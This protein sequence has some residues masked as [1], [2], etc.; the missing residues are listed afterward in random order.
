MH[1][2]MPAG[3]VVWLNGPT[4]LLAQ[5]VANEGIQ[6]RP[7]LAGPDETNPTKEQVYANAK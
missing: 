1:V 6:K 3:V 2:R 4:D 5:R 7:L